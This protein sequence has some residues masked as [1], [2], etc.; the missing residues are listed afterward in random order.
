MQSMIGNLEV[1]EV[2]SSSV[3]RFGDAVQNTPISTSNPFAGAGPF[4]TGDFVVTNIDVSATNTKDA[5][6]SDS[7]TNS[8][9]NVGVK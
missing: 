9:G 3:L 6:I 8:I 7:E 4:I 1:V 2:D 5:D